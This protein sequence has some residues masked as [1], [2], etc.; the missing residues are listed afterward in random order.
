VHVIARQVA[1]RIRAVG[2]GILAWVDDSQCRLEQ[3][4]SVE[5]HPLRD[6]LRSFFGLEEVR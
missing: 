1:E 4:K 5:R 2:G 6:L 3:A